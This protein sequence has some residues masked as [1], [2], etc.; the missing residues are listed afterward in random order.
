MFCYS[1]EP[2][3]QLTPLFPSTLPSSMCINLINIQCYK[4]WGYAVSNYV[5]TLI[6]I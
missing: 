2:G 4:Y 3:M 6:V 1:Y 5:K